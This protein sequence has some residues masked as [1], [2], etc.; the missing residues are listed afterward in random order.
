MSHKTLRLIAATALVLALSSPALAAEPTAPESTKTATM[1][2]DQRA[3]INDPHMHA[4][5]Q[6]AVTAF[7]NG[8]ARVDKPRFE[9]DARAI[10]RDF[11]RATG[12]G[13][14]AMEDHLKLIPD[15]VIQI[16]TEDPKVLASYDN[17]IAALLGPQ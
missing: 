7:A 16:A 10:F 1:Q 14:D 4:F 13:A 15:Q 2:G 17:F 8:P 6:L 9:Q 5:Y 11:G 12:A 3:W